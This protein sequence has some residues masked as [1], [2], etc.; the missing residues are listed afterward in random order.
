TIAARISDG[1]FSSPEPL[2]PDSASDLFLNLP[3]AA[4]SDAAKSFMAASRDEGEAGFL[5]SIRTVRNRSADPSGDYFDAFWYG[6]FL[7]AGERWPDAER[8]F[9]TAAGYAADS[10]ERDA[11]GW[12][13][14]EAAW[15][16]SGKETIAALGEALAASRNPGYYSDLIEPIS[17]EA[18]VARDGAALAALDAAVRQKASARDAARLAYLCARAAQVGIISDAHILA[19]FGSG[20]AGA[21]DYAEARLRY[22]YGQRADEW[23]RLAAA[24]RLGE[25]LVEPLAPEPPETAAVGGPASGKPAAA[26]PSP[27]GDAGEVSPD[28]YATALARFGLGARIRK[29]LGPEFSAVSEGTVRLAAAALGE[30]GRHDQAYRLIATQFWKS[31]FV[32]TRLD[33]E[34]YWPRPYRESFSEAARSTG[35]DESLLYG[36]ARSESA[37]DPGAVSKSGAIGLTQLMPATAA[38]MAGRLRIKEYD[39]ADPDDNVAIGSAYFAR[40]LGAVDGRVLPA[41]FSYNG[42]PTRFRRWEAEYGKLPLDLL[43]EALSYAETRQYGRNV[44]SA[45]LQ[46]AALYGERDLRDYFAYLIGEGPRPD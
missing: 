1:V 19:A 24:Y 29:E 42:G 34:L 27:S 44:A 36:L 2:T 16:R 37:F 43:L 11:A 28:G 5:H 35:L 6:R 30:A 3:R 46:Y 14:V 32:P 9:K 13:A 26:P 45:A 22:A 40:V 10:F 21:A 39:L 8:W 17:R 4:A 25:P 41:V 15:K 7:R 38:E 31:G 23:Y 18:L 33:A 12:Y 20:F